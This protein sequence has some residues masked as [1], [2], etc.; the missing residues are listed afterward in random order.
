VKLGVALDTGVAW[1]AQCDRARMAEE[2]GFDLLWIEADDAITASAL[3]GVTDRI[4][5]GLRLPTGANPLILAEEVAVADLVLGGRLVVALAGDDLA[6]TVEVVLSSLAPRPF[7]HG[8]PKWK[9]PA[10][11]P[12]NVE[13]ESRVL[14]TPFAAQIQLPVWVAGPGA[15]QAAAE[16]GLSYVAGPDE[17]SDDLRALWSEIESAIGPAAA[18]LPRPAVRRLDGEVDAAHTVAALRAERSAWGLDVAILH[19]ST[20]ALETIANEIRSPHG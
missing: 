16:F 5:V 13:T 7:A 17:S 9:V 18:R 3:A 19:A 6:E 20:D 12:T 8:G 1:D 2:L 10:N 11:H 4:G 14:V 15:P